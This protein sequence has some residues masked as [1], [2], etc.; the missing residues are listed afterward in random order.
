VWASDDATGDGHIFVEIV[1]NT[2]E[3]AT[4]R[5]NVK[6][7]TRVN[8]STIRGEPILKLFYINFSLLIHVIVVNV[9]IGDDDKLLRLEGGEAELCELP[10]FAERDR[11]LPITENVEFHHLE[12][13]ATAKS[14]LSWIRSQN[15]CSSYSKDSSDRRQATDPA[16]VLCL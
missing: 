9:M 13:R 6:Q 7:Q 5:V 15:V 14:S 11:A 12:S 1:P 3:N 10:A 16:Q 8:V 4:I 2:H